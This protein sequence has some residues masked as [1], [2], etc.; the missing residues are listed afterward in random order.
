MRTKPLENNRHRH[1]GAASAF[2]RRK[3]EA[4]RRAV[5]R[6]RFFAP[7]VHVGD[8]W[9]WV[10][11]TSRHVKRSGYT[12]FILHVTKAAGS[13]FIWTAHPHTFRIVKP[14]RVAR[15]CI[16]LLNRDKRPKQVHPMG[17]ID[18]DDEVVPISYEQWQKAVGFIQLK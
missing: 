13:W 6:A 5:E 7:Y 17:L 10:V 12:G 15:V 2:V 11:L 16:T 8:G 4:L 1:D 18:L 9:E 14:K 3:Y